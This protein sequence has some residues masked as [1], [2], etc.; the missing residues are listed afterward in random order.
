MELNYKNR[1]LVEKIESIRKKNGKYSIQALIPPPRRLQ[2]N[3][4]YQF[5][6]V[7]K[8]LNYRNKVD[9]SFIFVIY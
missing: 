5:K 2:K 4:L 8:D 9:E 7:Q 1:I 3:K 6:K